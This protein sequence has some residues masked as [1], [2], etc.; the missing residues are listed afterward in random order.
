MEGLQNRWSAH[1]CDQTD[2]AASPSPGD[3]RAW[4]SFGGAERVQ[5]ALPNV[6]AVHARRLRTS[7]APT[8]FVPQGHCPDPDLLPAPQPPHPTPRASAGGWGGPR[9]GLLRVCRIRCWGSRA[10]SPHSGPR[11]GWRQGRRRQTRDGAAR[12]RVCVPVN[13]RVGVCVCTGVCA[14][15]SVSGRRPPHHQGAAGRGEERLQPSENSPTSRPFF[16]GAGSAHRPSQGRHRESPVTP[17]RCRPPPPPV[18]DVALPLLSL[19]APGFR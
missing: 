6:P 16:A 19:L 10:P 18:A 12:A 3:S 13:V 15:I 5:L 9:P 1:T 2:A 7:S 8:P 11:H 4:R 17:L 14:C